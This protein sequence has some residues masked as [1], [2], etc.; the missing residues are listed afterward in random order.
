VNR[1]LTPITVTATIIREYHESVKI[2]SADGKVSVQNTQK[3]EAV[4]EQEITI[5]PDQANTIPFIPKH[6]GKHTV[7][8]TG[9]DKNGHTFSTAS[10]L[11]VYGTKEYPWA[12]EDGMSIKLIP[13]KKQYLPGETAR[14][15]VMT[16]IEGTAIVTLERSG[17]HSE[18]RRSL[19]ADNP[20]IEIPLTDMEAPNVFVSVIVI[21]GA[22]ESPRKQKEPALK[23]GYCTLNVKNVKDA[24][25]VK[26]AVTGSEHR[27]GGT[28]EVEG[29]VTMHDGSPAA[30]AE[31]VFYA[32]DEGTLAV[33]G[34]QTPNLMDFFHAPRPLSIDSG[35]SFSTFGSVPQ[36]TIQIHSPATESSPSPCTELRNLATKQPITR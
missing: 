34:Y 27:P 26:L 1:S 29:I 23:L 22:E 25:D 31:V 9:K 17:V 24:L 13:E 8:L 7:T 6:T 21:R 19:K 15:L 5:T 16:P 32:E 28:T 20:V 33:T 18:Y 4:S 11:Q 10:A 2:K 3:T 36:S 35:T 12:T 14:I 30:G